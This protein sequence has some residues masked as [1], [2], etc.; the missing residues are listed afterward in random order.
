MS[1]SYSLVLEFLDQGDV[2]KYMH[3]S[4]FEHSAKQNLVRSLTPFLSI[5]L[6]HV[7][8]SILSY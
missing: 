3:I 8:V 2:V 6:D 5:T 1:K 4:C 7:F